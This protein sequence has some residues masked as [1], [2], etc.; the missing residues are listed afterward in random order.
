MNVGVSNKKSIFIKKF[1]V[2]TC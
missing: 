1:R 2:F